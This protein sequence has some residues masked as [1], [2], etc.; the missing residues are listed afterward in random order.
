M[1]MEFEYRKLS[2]E[3]AKEIDSK[4]FTD[5]QGKRIE[6]NCMYSVTNK[7][8]TIVFQQIWFSHEKDEPDKY[9]LAYKGAYYYI[10][11]YLLDITG[12]MVDGNK[13]WYYKFDVNKIYNIVPEVLECPT[14]EILQLLKSVLYIKHFYGSKTRK[15]GD[16]VFIEVMYK[17]E[18]I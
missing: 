3:R 15:A 10:D 9:F 12:Q 16:E 6:I 2:A 5:W 1:K 13:Y 11:M 7:D 17:G 14:E 4:D 8:E 18:I